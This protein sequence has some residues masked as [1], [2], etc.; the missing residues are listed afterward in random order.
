MAIASPEIPSAGRLT[1]LILATA[2][3][4]EALGLADDQT[5]LEFLVEPDP[6]ARLLPILRLSAFGD[7]FDDLDP[8]WLLASLVLLLHPTMDAS[9]EWPARIGALPAEMVIASA[10]AMSRLVPGLTDATPLLT[11]L[12]A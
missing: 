8:R 3:A 9:V 10:L 11:R 7:E 12:G 5:R 6:A 4:C 2:R 1:G